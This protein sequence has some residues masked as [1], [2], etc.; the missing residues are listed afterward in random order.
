MIYKL[1]I[2]SDE[3]E[4][5]MRVIEIQESDSFLVLHTAIQEACGYNNTQMTSFFVS[6]QQWEKLTE[7]TLMDMHDD[8]NKILIMNSCNLNDYISD[9]NDTLIYTFDHFNDRSLFITLT[10]IKDEEI[11]CA[12]PRCTHK[13]GTPPEMTKD[14]DISSLFNDLLLDDDF[15]DDDFIAD[16]DFNE[17]ND[18]EDDEY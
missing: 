5:F 14:D 11:D 18:Y 7:I 9:I 16:E 6:N 17:Y 3:V 13:A 8:E 12:Y 1:R 2:I 10:A 4:T 15:S